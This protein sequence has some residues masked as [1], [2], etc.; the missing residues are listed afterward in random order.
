MPEQRLKREDNAA[1]T[2]IRDRERPGVTRR[3]GNP[4]AARYF[5]LDLSDDHHVKN[6]WL[7]L[8]GIGV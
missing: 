1:R 2:K 7:T 6:Q 3:R 4:T 5:A 8:S